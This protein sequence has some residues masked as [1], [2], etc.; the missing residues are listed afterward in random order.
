MRFL[1]SDQ[2]KVGKFSWNR[3]I[4]PPATMLGRIILGILVLAETFISIFWI[5]TLSS[6]GEGYALMA[7]VPY[8][9]IIFSYTTLLIFYRY[10][11]YEYFTFTQLVML[12]VMPFFMQWVIGG[13]E[14]SSGIAIW[15][16]LSPVGALLIV[17]YRQSLP[18][19]CLFVGLVGISWVLNSTFAASA[20]PIPVH[21]KNIYFA[22][23]LLGTAA[24]LYSILG[25]F[26]TQKELVMATLAEEQNK[27]EKLLLNVLPESVAN[28]LKNNDFDTAR[29][30]KAVT[31]MFADL[32]NFTALSADMSAA[33]LIDLLNQVFTKFDDLTEKYGVE[34]IKTIGDAY[35]VVS[36]APEPRMNH[37]EVIAKMA[38]DIQDI[39]TEIS[40]SSG[41]DL[42]MRVGINSGP[43]ISGVIGN[44]K[45]SYDLWGDTVNMA[46]RME[47]HGVPGK[48]Q[49]TQATYKLLKNRYKFER[50]GVIEIKGKGKVTTHFLV[51]PISA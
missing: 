25:Y 44:R 24:I 32:V 37:A 51:S 41:K 50:R 9:Y 7:A 19:F 43:V 16:I 35:M 6:L 36:G 28:K 27:T 42:K 40:A 12:L 48:I 10:Q 4:Y 14:A 47:Q 13:F 15:A 29:D 22:I 33:A 20:L 17:G 8:V 21:L 18:W 39:L 3:L 1:F 26:Q 11:R 38:L 34:K 45:F 31:I 49:V 46:S 30:H 23:N 5:Y 2:L